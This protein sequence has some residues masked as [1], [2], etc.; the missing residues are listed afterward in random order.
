M[1]VLLL[2]FHYKMNSHGSVTSWNRYPALSVTLGLRAAA[3]PRRLP[4]PRSPGRL[5]PAQHLPEPLNESTQHPRQN[6]TM[7]IDRGTVLANPALV[8]HYH[9]TQSALTHRGTQT[10]RPFDN[11]GELFPGA[12]AASTLRNAGQAIN[13]A[14]EL[15]L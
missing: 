15:M 7:P 2:G 6:C 4:V 3:A 9:P 5:P 8:I 12:V 10:K 11:K 14:N 13:I 1:R